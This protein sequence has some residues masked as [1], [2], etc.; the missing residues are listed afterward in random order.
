MNETQ[1]SKVFIDHIDDVIRYYW[2]KYLNSV[3]IDEKQIYFNL[4]ENYKQLKELHS[5]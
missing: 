1:L 3:T 5:L 2:H 4:Y